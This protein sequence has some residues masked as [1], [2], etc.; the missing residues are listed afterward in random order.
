MFSAVTNRFWLRLLS[1]V[2]F[3]CAVLELVRLLEVLVEAWN[4]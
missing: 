1:G 4:V 2:D 3:P